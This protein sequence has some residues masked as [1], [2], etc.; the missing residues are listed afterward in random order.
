M[1]KAVDVRCG[2][3]RRACCGSSATDSVHRGGRP[4]TERLMRALVVGELQVLPQAQSRVAGRGIVVQ[5]DLLV[6]DGAPAP[7]DE[8]RIQR[9]APALHADP[10]LGGP[11]QGAV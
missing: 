4:V 5:V 10:D 2:M 1:S 6:L 8:D 11:E 3:G 7:F 9:A